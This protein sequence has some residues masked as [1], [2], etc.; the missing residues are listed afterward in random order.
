M[1]LSTYLSAVDQTVTSDDTITVVLLLL[2]AELIASVGLQH[3]VLSEG[4]VI[5]EQGKTLTSSELATLVLGVNTLLST[6]QKSSLSGLLQTCSE[7][8]LDRNNGWLH[9]LLSS[10][11]S[12]HNHSRG[13]TAIGTNQ[14]SQHCK[15]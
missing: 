8:S 5:Q 11:V 4:S 6:T 7:S 2:H 1:G 15:D 3:V 10:E 13:R 12:G 9:L 14:V